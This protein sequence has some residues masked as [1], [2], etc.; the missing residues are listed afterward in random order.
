MSTTPEQPTGPAVPVR[1]ATVQILTSVEERRQIDDLGRLVAQALDVRRVSTASVLLGLVQL[2][3]TDD[4]VFAQLVE[5]VNAAASHPGK[6]AV[7]R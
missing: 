5:H 1:K 7:Q 3:R 2:G 6:R 4:L